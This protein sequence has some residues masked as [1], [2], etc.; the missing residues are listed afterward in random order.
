MI[1]AKVGFPGSLVGNIHDLIDL[2]RLVMI[3]RH[4]SP[5]RARKRKRGGKAVYRS[6][7]CGFSF[8]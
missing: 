8:L 2:R 1:Y 3:G 7:M 5:S 6:D 4:W